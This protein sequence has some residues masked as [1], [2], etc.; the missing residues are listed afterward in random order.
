MARY[1]RAPVESAL[2]LLYEQGTMA[3]MDDARLVAMLCDDRGTEAARAAFAAL[4]GRHGPMVWGTCVMALP[5]RT[6]A[7]DAFQATFLVL[8]RRAGQVRVGDSLGRWLHGVARRVAART[9]EKARK[10]PE[11]LGDR[12]VWAESAAVAESLEIA[13]ILRQEVAR[14]PRI[15]REVVTLCHLDSMPLEE[16]AARIERPVGTVKGRLARGRD[17]LRKRLVRRGFCLAVP[18]GLGTAAVDAAVGGMESGGLDAASGSIAAAALAKGVIQTM[19]MIRAG[20]IAAGI[21]LAGGAAAVAWRVQEGGARSATAGVEVAE[22]RPSP[23]SK[24]AEVAAAPRELARVNYPAYVV[25]PPDLIRIEVLEALPGRPITGERLVR[26]DGTISLDFYGDLHVGGLTV[27]QIKEKVIE[28]LRQFLPD[29][30]LGLVEQYEEGETIEIV[31]IP[32]RNSDR[33]FV[34]VAAYNSK[35]YFVQGDVAQP[36]RLICMGNETV[37]DAL[38]YAGGFLPSADLANIR[39]VRP[40]GS[41]GSRDGKAVVLPVD[42]EGIVDRGDTSTNYQLFP[43]DRVIVYR[44]PK[45]GLTRMDEVQY[46]SATK[47]IERIEEKMAGLTEELAQLRRELKGLEPGTETPATGDGP[48]TKAEDSPKDRLPAAEAPKE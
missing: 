39:L 2:G 28:R 30:I 48:A 37:L 29:E 26:P 8:A 10:R 12:D 19:F 9:A 25:E 11:G 16:A 36:T 38:V 4:V 43:G 21:V 3:S 22:K 33:V 20:L 18:A 6:D 46:Y 13:G 42:Y 44:D 45:S 7:E 41:P 40:A 15:Y 14:L 32:P 5:H 35:V 23:P 17:L 47:R 31:N 1:P 24:A 27:T 34:D